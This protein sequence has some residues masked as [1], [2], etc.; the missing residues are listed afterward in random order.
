M[1]FRSAA[2]NRMPFAVSD[3]HSNSE[4]YPGDK[5]V[6]GVIV[7][8]GIS[9]ISSNLINMSRPGRSFFYTT[10]PF[11]TASAMANMLSDFTIASP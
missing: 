7:R 4:V 6:F 11:L 1:D 5:T 9:N 2:H 3:T 8:N 10:V